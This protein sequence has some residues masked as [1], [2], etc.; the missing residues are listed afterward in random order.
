MLGQQVA[1]FGGFDNHPKI[2]IWS[3]SRWIVV[4][5]SKTNWGEFSPN[6][7]FVFQNRRNLVF[8]RIWSLQISR[9]KNFLLDKNCQILFQVLM[10]SQKY[11]RNFKCLYF[12]FFEL[13]N[14]LMDGYTRSQIWAGKKN[15]SCT[16]DIVACRC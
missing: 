6:G 1:E 14:H 16:N 7:N 8:L 15:L 13:P 4:V 11:R 3:V 2:F 5:V 9:K 10:G 12:L